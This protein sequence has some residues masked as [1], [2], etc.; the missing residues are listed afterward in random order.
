VRR[1]RRIGGASAAPRPEPSPDRTLAVRDLD[2]RFGGVHAL[3]GVSL[4]CRSGEIVGLIGPN[5]A[6]KTTLL[7]VVAGVFAPDGGEIRVGDRRIDGLD[8]HEIARLGIARTFQSI[9]LFGRL[10]V[11]QN[12]EVSLVTSR[13]H[14]RDR[15]PLRADELLAGFELRAVAE[16]PAG[17][18]AYGVQRRVE[19]ARALAL[20][21]SHLLLDE[22]AAGANQAESEV[23]VD[24]VQ[25][26]RSFHGCGLLVVDHDLRFVMS[27]CDRVYVLNEGELIA[28]GTPSEIRRDPKVRRVYLGTSSAGQGAG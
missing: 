20:A 6:G 4:D 9:R 28:H 11:R 23:L 3:R 24:L 27:A 5:G 12:L 15:D 14:R 1:V 2:K 13:R 16:Y 10:T 26:I 7:N 21:P 19:I 22:P 8:P 17:T 18:L 25:G